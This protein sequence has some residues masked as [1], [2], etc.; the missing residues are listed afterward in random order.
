[1]SP[2]VVPSAPDHKNSSGRNALTEQGKQVAKVN[3]LPIDPTF[4]GSTF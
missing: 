3:N 1:M 4:Y 2:M